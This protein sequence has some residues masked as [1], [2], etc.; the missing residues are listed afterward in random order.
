MLDNVFMIKDDIYEVVDLVNFEV[1]IEVD[2][3]GKCLIVFDK[4]IFVI[5]DYFWDFFD[6]KYIDFFELFDIEKE[7]MVDFD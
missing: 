7:Y 4:I 6:V 2:C 1:M 5:Y 3:Y